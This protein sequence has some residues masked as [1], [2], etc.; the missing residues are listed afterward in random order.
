MMR[1]R[2][3]SEYSADEVS[4]RVRGGLSEIDGSL[5]AEIDSLYKI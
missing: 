2:S 5:P 1:F 4:I 3:V